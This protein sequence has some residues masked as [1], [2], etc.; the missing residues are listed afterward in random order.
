MRVGF[1]LDGV[2]YDFGESVRRYLDSI[3]QVYG[4]KDDAHEPHHWDFYEYWHMTREDFVQ[5]CHDGVDAGFI[6]SGPARPNAAEAVNRV[7]DLGHE[8]IIIT[9]RFFGGKPENSH[10]ATTEWL[11]E[12]GIPYHEL[13]FSPNKL[14]VPTD[15]F[16]EDKLENYDALTAGGVKTFLINRAWNAVE[17]GDARNRINDI[18]EYAD[19]IELITSDGFADL[20]FA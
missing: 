2:L 20:T 15:T 7:A 10:T 5:V 17:G 6:F 12:H 9:D 14:L 1:D 16:V 19:A 3:G 4:W 13:H 18:S 11:A 8:I